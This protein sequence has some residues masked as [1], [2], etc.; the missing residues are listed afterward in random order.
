MARAVRDTVLPLAIVSGSFDTVSVGVAV[1]G[2]ARA[3]GMMRT[4]WVGEVS[5][6]E[7][8]R[9]TLKSKL[10]TVLGATEYDAVPSAAMELL[11]TVDQA[12]CPVTRR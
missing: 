7:V 3:V 11:R 5:A 8:P 1:A 10:R 4:V 2:T 6:G 9:T 12:D